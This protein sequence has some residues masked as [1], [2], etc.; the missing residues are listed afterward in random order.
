MQPSLHLSYHDKAADEYVD[1]SGLESEMTRR[2]SIIL[3]GTEDIR[4]YVYTVQVYT[5][6]GSTL[7]VERRSDDSQG[8]QEMERWDTG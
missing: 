7:K 1:R 8:A 5:F 3:L 2:N 6:Y 4:C